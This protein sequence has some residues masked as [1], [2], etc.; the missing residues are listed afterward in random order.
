MKS[1]V[2][3]LCGL[4]S[5]GKSY[6]AQKLSEQEKVLWLDSD[7]EILRLNAGFATCRDLYKALGAEEFRKKEEQAIKSLLLQ[8]SAKDE[9]VVVSLGGGVC[10]AN[11]SLKL[12][13]AHGILVYLQ[14]S[15]Q[16]LYQRML[17]GGLPPY[18]TNGPKDS[19]ETFHT[20]YVKRDKNYLEF[21]NYVI[22]LYKWSEK[23]VLK[24][25]KELI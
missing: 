6:Y 12:V 5:C 10:E 17:A 18:L 15:E 2:L 23:E 4:K 3:F 19:K 22:K 16:V 21:S 1:K 24:Q 11:N 13:Q 14:E 9:P 25:L 8:I 7:Q 20:L